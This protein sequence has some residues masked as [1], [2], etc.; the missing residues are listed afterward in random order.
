MLVNRLKKRTIATFLVKNTP[1]YGMQMLLVGDVRIV[2][3]T[4]A[5]TL[6]GDVNGD[7]EVD[8]RDITALIDVIMNSIT[9]NQRADVNGDSEI[10]VRDITA[11]IDI[12]MNA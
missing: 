5:A 6:R 12:I 11:L 7:G 9:N 8:V 4:P 2:D 1:H 10:D 3:K